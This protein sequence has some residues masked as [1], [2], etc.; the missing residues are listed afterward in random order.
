VVT[1][2][3]N[4]PSTDVEIV[5]ISRSSYRNPGYSVPELFRLVRSGYNAYRLNSLN[6]NGIFLR[7]GIG[8]GKDITSLPPEVHYVVLKFEIH[9]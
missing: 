6:A 3:R 1:V 7:R 5:I 9:G 8:D 2:K 4:T